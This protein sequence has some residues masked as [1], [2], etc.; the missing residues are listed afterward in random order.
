V[1]GGLEA[2]GWP[3][4]A[5]RLAARATPG[6]QLDI[7]PASRVHLIVQPRIEMPTVRLARPGE[8]ES[9]VGALLDARDLT[10]RWA[11]ADVWR[12]QREAAP[13]RLREVS[14][15]TLE[16]RWQR[17]ADGVSNWASPEAAGPKKEPTPLPQIDSLRLTQGLARLD[18]A[19]LQ[20]QA[21]A[22]FGT[23][24]DGSWQARVAGTLRGQA[25]SLA[26]TAAS[27]LPL[28]ASDADAPPVGL[29]AKL[30]QGRSRVSFT[31]SAASLLDSRALDGRVTVAGPSLAAV[32][33]PLGVTLPATPPFELSGRLRH[34]GG[35][36]QLD[37][38]QAQIG[39]SRLGGD[40]AFDTRPARPRLT[41]RLTGGPLAL[42]DLG[43]AVGTDT[44]PSRPGRVLPDK[45]IDVPALGAMDAALDIQLSRL[46]LGTPAI[47]PLTMITAK[48]SLEQGL[49]ALTE[50]RAGVAGGSV[51]GS[52]QLDT[53]P[54]PPQLPVWQAR[55][56]LDGVA[57]D[58]W[59][60]SLRRARPGEAE[61]ASLLTG[62][63]QARADVAG[64]GRSTAALL[65][66]M[67][68]SL[69]VNLQDARMSHLITEVMGLD[70]AQGLGVLFRG[71]QNLPLNCARLEGRFTQGVL[72]PQMAVVDNRDSRVELTGQV[73]LATEQLAL[74]AVARPKDFSPLTLRAPLR[75]EGSLAEPRI[76]LEGKALGGK[77]LAAIALGALAPPAALLAFVDAGE[78]LPPLDCQPRPTP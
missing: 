32:G 18:D 40:F 68:G 39:A 75:V 56:A 22:Q 46:D 11:W 74:R 71:D 35:L 58:R 61:P 27:A 69:S 43:P 33:R 34:A 13:L 9:Q 26:A 4:L 55:L 37:G 2:A 17:G 47:A 54:A 16:L 42:A 21:E 41:G 45:P 76:A 50:L 53:R 29:S 38:T 3:G 44:A 23:Q 64:Q 59:L 14:A 62:K 25:L 19:P 57:V 78:K 10:V 67:N 63:L 65:G 36:W 72:R 7:A 49:L 77:A 28:L 1:V 52:T 20:L 66:S 8:A 70:I 6:L 12:W 24:A 31:G 73:S 5:P 48:L 30:S 60:R 15:A 51:S